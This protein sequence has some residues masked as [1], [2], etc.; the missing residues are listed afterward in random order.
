MSAVWD[1]MINEVQGVFVKPVDIALP[2]KRYDMGKEVTAGR[3][4][5]KAVKHA[6]PAAVK[7]GEPVKA[8][9]ADVVRE[10]IREAK[11]TGT[12]VEQVVASVVQKLGMAKAL[13]TSYVKNNWNKV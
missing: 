10:M 6:G 9:K 5:N 3:A 13:A 8:T 1:A 12:P 4:V 7:T 2:T 11:D